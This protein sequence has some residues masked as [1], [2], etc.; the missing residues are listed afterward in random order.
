MTFFYSLGNAKRAIAA[1]SCGGGQGIA[2][3]FE[4]I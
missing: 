4:S 3:M 1:S 2:V